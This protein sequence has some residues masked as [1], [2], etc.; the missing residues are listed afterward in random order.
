MNNFKKALGGLVA[1]P[2]W[3]VWRMV[4]DGSK[5]KYDPKI[6]VSAAGFNVDAQVSTSWM[7]FDA[8]VAQRNA[9][10]MR[11]LRMVWFIRLGLCLLQIAVTGSM[12]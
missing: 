5:S 7:T 8:A 2:Q 11:G 10:R 12:I 6:P 3:F 1:I 4:W 9:Q